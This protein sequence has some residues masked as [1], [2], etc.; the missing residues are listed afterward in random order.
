MRDV[1]ELSSD[2]ALTRNAMVKAYKE[3]ARDRSQR[4]RR[5]YGALALHA[6]TQ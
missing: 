5:K 4:T 6:A 2:D 3:S 1:M